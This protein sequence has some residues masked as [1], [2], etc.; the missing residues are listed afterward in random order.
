ML[1]FLALIMTACLLAGLVL[2]ADKPV[3]DDVIVDQVRVKLAADAVVKGGGLGVDSKAG[4]VTLSGVVATSKQKD[5]AAKVAS[6]VRGV[7]QVVN[8]IALAPGGK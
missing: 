6:K 4:V 2:A 5:R 8:N 3:S 7:K 1:K